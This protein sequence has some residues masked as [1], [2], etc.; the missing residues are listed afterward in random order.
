[1]PLSFHIPLRPSF[2]PFLNRPPEPL[3]CNYASQ[4][5]VYNR[6]IFSTIVFLTFYLFYIFAIKLSAFCDHPD[7]HPDPPP[8]PLP[9]PLPFFRFSADARTR[10]SLDGFGRHS[11]RSTPD[12]P[13]PHT[14]SPIP[15][16]PGAACRLSPPLTIAGIP[17][18]GLP[19]QRLENAAV[20]REP[21]PGG[22]PLPRPLKAD[23]AADRPPG[24]S[25][26]PEESRIP[27]GNRGGIRPPPPCQS[28]VTPGGAHAQKPAGK[29]R[30][31]AAAPLSERRPGFTVLQADRKA[32]QGKAAPR[33]LAA[34]VPTGPLIGI[35]FSSL[36]LLNRMAACGMMFSSRQPAEGGESRC[37][38]SCTSCC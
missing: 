11:G 22:G 9:G 32:V 37:P 16:H 5:V 3:L 4:Q 21:P 7:P 36:S 30:R 1:M 13:I 6:I 24:R 14:S 38:V 2:L 23:C 8:G 26:P 34:R 20:C 25:P 28:G 17:S 12:A 33:A 31:P 18:C 35:H 29:R 15:A 10:R 27:P 19:F